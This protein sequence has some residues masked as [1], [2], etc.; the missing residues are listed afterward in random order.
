MTPQSRQLFPSRG[1]ARTAVTWLTAAVAL[2]VA[3][4]SA[5]GLLVGGLYTDPPA[6]AV[7]FR[8]YDLVTLVLVAPLLVL[9]LVPSLR[10]RVTTTLLRVGLLAFCVYDYAYY[11]FGAELNAT[12]LAH[13]AIFTGSL[14]ALVLS[15]M[16]LDVAALAEH[17]AATTPVR[18]V[19][20]ILALLGGA[21]AAIQLLGLATFAVTGAAPQEPSQLVVPL[22][23]TRLGAVLDLALLVPTYLLAAVLLWRRRGGG[24]LIA[25]TVLVAGLLHQA[26]YVSG[27]LFQLA[28]D[29]PGAAFDPVEPVIIVLY[30]AAAVLL[31]AN[32][33][34]DAHLRVRVSEREPTLASR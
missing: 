20:A 16:T 8:G 7:M 33:R 34:G 23:F 17:F 29:I 10:D 15:V 30:L 32:V 4:A 18:T 19:A 27:M 22:T 13:V 11:L 28:A 3:G 24:Y 31:L 21:L 12:L 25:V 2:L 9:T 5:A 1:A 14:Y 26:S 6:V